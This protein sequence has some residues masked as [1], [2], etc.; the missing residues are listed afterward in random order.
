MGW[1][2]GGVT[3]QLVNRLCFSSSSEYH[4]CIASVFVSY[5]SLVSD[6]MVP[7]ALIVHVLFLFFSDSLDICFFPLTLTISTLYETSL[8][9]MPRLFVWD[10]LTHKPFNTIDQLVRVTPPHEKHVHRKAWQMRVPVG[11]V[12]NEL[13]W[14]SLFTVFMSEFILIKHQS[15]GKPIHYNSI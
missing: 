6:I 9:T 8:S 1:L 12:F 10:T 4:L 5:C 2:K 14:K 11:G 7:N 3:T 13:N 15:A